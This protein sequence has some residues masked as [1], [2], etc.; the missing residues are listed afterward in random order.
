MILYW[1]LEREQLVEMMKLHLLTKKSFKINGQ[2]KLYGDQGQNQWWLG[3]FIF[4]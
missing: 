1:L 4:W 3:I 2:R